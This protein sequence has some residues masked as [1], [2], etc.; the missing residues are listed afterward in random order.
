MTQTPCYLDEINAQPAVVANFITRVPG[1][2]VD[3]D[4]AATVDRLRPAHESVVRSMGFEWSQLHLA[5]QVHGVEVAVVSVDD[6][7]EVCAG[8]D[9][10]IT[11]DAG[12]LL[13]IYVA[14]CGAVYISDPVKGVL[15]LLHS[16][17]KGTEGNII[18]RAISIMRER[19][20]CRP[21]DMEVALAPCIRPPAYDVDFASEIHRQALH[22]GV[23]AS[24]Y[25]DS[26]ICTSLDLEEYYSYRV[27]KGKT[28]RMLALLGR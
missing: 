2:L 5:E 3:T 16:G 18:G 27:E 1:V 14:D 13:G 24:H 20:G 11:A 25:T 4:R 23:L 26:G 21:E 19:F 6:P 10:L 9:G 12:V 15:A 22:A 7:V 28:G 8:V 17:K